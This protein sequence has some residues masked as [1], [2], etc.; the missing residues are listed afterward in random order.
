MSAGGRDCRAILLPGGGAAA[1][2]G[3]IKSLRLAGYRGRLVA[4]DADP[5]AVGA[6]LAD[7]F[8]VLPPAHREDFFPAALRV[9][10]REGIDL[11]LATSGFDIFPYSQRRAELEARG[12]TVA[13]APPD[14]LETCADKWRFYLV[15]GATFPLPRTWQ[16][17]DGAVTYPCFAK[18]VRGKGSRDGYVCATPAELAFRLRHRA[19]LIVQEYLPGEE[20]TVDVLADLDGRPVVAVPRVRLE[21]RGGVSMKGRIVRDREIEALCLDM[22]AFLRLP[23]ASCMQLRRGRSGRPYFL[24]VNS[25]FGGGT[26]FATLAGVNLPAL[27]LDLVAGRPCA[28]PEP[29][30]ITVARYFEEVVL[31]GEV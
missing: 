4:T 21:T 20:Y 26:V 7:A 25:R 14:V 19:D 28:P 18:P 3:V 17:G 22:A 31:D 2:V 30:P 1:A 6:R 16:P 27:L 5:V 29:R 8:Y 11:V 13:I 23:A 24:E 12:V 15:V 10:E 9:I